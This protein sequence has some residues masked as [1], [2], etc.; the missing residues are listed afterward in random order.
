LIRRALGRTLAPLREQDGFTLVESV[1]AALLVGIASVGVLGVLDTSR[2]ATYRAEQSQVASDIA[3]REME[4]I[5]ALDY[6]KVALTSN[7]GGSADGSDPRTRVSGSKFAL[8]R[9]GGSQADMVVNGGVLNGPLLSGGV[10]GDPGTIEGGTVDPG[11]SPFESGD[12][13]GTIHRFVVWQDDPNC[14]PLVCPGTQDFK[15]VVVAVALD[16]TGS[17]GKRGYVEIQTDVIDPD[18]TVLSDVTPEQLGDLTVAQQFWLSDTR[19]TTGPSD[20]DRDE[21]SSHPAHDTHGVS[22]AAGSSNR[23]KALLLSA[24]PNDNYPDPPPPVDPPA[25]PDFSTDVGIDGV[26]DSGLQLLPSN[27]CSF[28]AS[29]SNSY[30]QNPVWVSRRMPEGFVMNS[31]VLELWTRRIESEVVAPARICVT[32][33]TRL[34][35]VDNSALP[36]VPDDEPTDVCLTNQATGQPYFTHEIQAWPTEWTRVRVPLDFSMEQQTCPPLSLPVPGPPVTLPDQRIGVAISIQQVSG[37]NTDLT[38]QYDHVDLDSRLEIETIPAS[39]D[40]LG[41]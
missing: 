34:D 39:V 9:N 15:R 6:S 28:R 14:L 3:Q 17:G 32:L 21:L 35:G 4:A 8:E 20:P 24:P 41:L 27:G 1:V 26:P 40:L 19:C 10:L 12:V 33:F 18:D 22:C 36:L 16:S 31:G 37:H 38:F 23:P 25:A 13:S 11:P 30:K 7:P 5:R 2:R 29:G